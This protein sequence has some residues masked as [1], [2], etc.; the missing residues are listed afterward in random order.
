MFSKL[1]KSFQKKYLIISPR[2]NSFGGVFEMYTGVKF[3]S[4][5]NKKFVLAVPL[6]NIHPKHKKKRIF[7][8]YFIYY[9]FKKLDIKSKIISF[10]LTLS[11]NLILILIKSKLLTIFD[12][13]FFR[14]QKK[15]FKYFPIYFGFDFENQIFQ[16][17]YDNQKKLNLN[18]INDL[19]NIIKINI[20]KFIP[21]FDVKKNYIISF[22]KD[23]NYSKS[24]A[25]G[26]LDAVAEIENYR[27]SYNF[28]LENGYYVERIGDSTL[29]NFEFS[30]KNYSD[31][32]KKKYSLKKQYL[33]FLKSNYFFG[34][35][36]S[37]A[38][39]ANYLNKP[40]II[41]NANLNYLYRPED[42]FN[43]RDM[44]IF[45]K[46]FCKK[47]KKI[48][49]FE[50][51]FNLDLDY[52]SNKSNFILIENSKEELLEFTKIF[53]Y[54]EKFND[55]KFFSLTKKFNEMLKI[56]LKKNSKKSIIFEIYSLNYFNIPDFYLEKYLYPNE[57]LN[58]ES[59][60]I[61]FN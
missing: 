19:N 42:H 27:E 25:E 31:N 8:L 41:S 17:Y 49:S 60:D 24:I 21:K 30:N 32:T 18:N 14:G 26:S 9:I 22:I 51:I 23:D 16:K 36:D 46:I 37:S 11:L 38:H 5:L 12:Y 29:K 50:E 6:L 44:I 3:A 55:Y 35:G 48:L 10:F 52:W 58:K 59:L 45:K 43:Q 13:I 20:Q 34:T 61:K 1:K 7:G 39:I 28:L 47:N 53:V 54:T 2:T 56:Y 33:S 40:R 57:S 4:F 15:I